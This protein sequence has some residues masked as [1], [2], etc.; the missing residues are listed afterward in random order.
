MPPPVPRSLFCA[1]IAAGILKVILDRG[2]RHLLQLAASTTPTSL[3]SSA[4]RPL[5]VFPRRTCS[6]RWSTTVRHRHCHPSQTQ[7]RVAAV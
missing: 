2:P 7:A 6:L 5:F 1:M 4:R 3:A